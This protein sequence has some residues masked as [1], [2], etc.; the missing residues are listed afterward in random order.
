MTNKEELGKKLGATSLLFACGVG[1]DCLSKAT[2]ELQSDS[3]LMGLSPYILGGIFTIGSNVVANGV[4][5]G[6]QKAK[7][8]FNKDLNSDLESII[9]TT[10]NETFSSIRNKIIEECNLQ[11]SKRDWL[12]RYFLK[13]DNENHLAVDEL[14]S[15]FLIPLKNFLK[16][17]GNIE[18]MLSENQQLEPDDYLFNAIYSVAPTY[19]KS[20]SEVIQKFTY[21]VLEKF[22]V[23]YRHHFLQNLKANENAKTAYYTHLLESILRNTQKIYSTTEEI[24]SGFQL[25]IDFS[26]EAKINFADILI[27]VNEIKATTVEIKYNTKEIINEVKELKALFVDF[28]IGNSK[29]ERFFVRVNKTDPS[30][31]PH[32]YQEL[33]IR[34]NLSLEPLKEYLSNGDFQNADKETIRIFHTAINESNRIFDQKLIVKF[35]CKIF[36]EIDLVWLK[37]SYGK[38]GFTPQ[39][40]IW[41]E[42]G[43]K[44]SFHLKTEKFAGAVGWKQNGSW[45]KNYNLLTF[46]LSANNGHLPSMTLPEYSN[47]EKWLASWIN[48]FKSLTVKY[49]LCLNT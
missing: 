33:L 7:E 35:P 27:G 3:S 39:Y 43:D 16:D 48:N 12:F 29:E 8:H 22:K 15:E 31:K 6:W 34:E 36:N 47:S 30:P 9:I 20:D 49:K 4:F 38:F 25:L 14:D 21:S 24:H 5:E 46:D 2:N 10:Y 23:A 26:S 41:N 28:L 42:L 44:Y 45:L 13:K 40:K 32:Y 1:L 17:N 18:K 11:E 19:Y 37:Y